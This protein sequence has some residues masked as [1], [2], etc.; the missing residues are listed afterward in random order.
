MKPLRLL[1][2]ALAA[3][4]TFLAFLPAL[5][6]GWVNFDDTTNFLNNPHYRGLG[7]AQIKWMFTDAVL[8]HYIPLT[9]LTLGL[10]YVLWGMDARG[11]HLTSVLFH[12]VN[13]VVFYFLVRRLLARGAPAP[14]GS[15]AAAS[16]FAAL[17]FS[18]HP[19]RV[20]SVAWIT[21]RRD[22]VSGLFFLLT[23]WAYLDL[24]EATEPSLR[25][26]LLPPALF[27]L[28]LLARANCVTLLAALVILDVYPLRRLG[29]DR[30][31]LGPSARAAWREKVPY[32]LMAVAA[33]WVMV[34]I[35]ADLGSFAP[36]EKEG[37][38]AQKAARA[39]YVLAFHVRKTLW[40]AELMPIYIRPPVFDPAEAR[41]LWSAAAVCALTALFI[42]LRR[43]WPAGLAV[44]AYYVAMLSPTL[45]LAEGISLTADH[46]SYLA[47]LGFPLLAGGAWLSLR[48][49]GVAAPALIALLAA[50]AL[51]RAA[52][53]QSKVW[54]DS[55]SLWQHTIGIDPS[56]YIA[57][58]NLGAVYRE[59]G[60]DDLALRHYQ[61]SV[62]HNPRYLQPYTNIAQILLAAGR[63]EEA[64]KTL[65]SVQRQKPGHLRSLILLS[66]V[67]KSLKQPVKAADYA[68]KAVSA[69]PKSADAANMFGILLL[70]RGRAGEAIQYFERAVANDPLYAPGYNNIGVALAALGRREQAAAYYA[71][72]V[73][74]NPGYAR[75]HL[76][77]AAA[78]EKLGKADSA[79]AHREKAAALTGG[80]R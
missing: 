13:A 52:W 28:T 3:L 18:L 8:G 5:Q 11:Y 48:R 20:D 73:A 66:E 43:R 57:H 71:K 79:K 12:C 58:N 2:P 1:P 40:P 21:E 30:G 49:A 55:E 67:H 26:K 25:Q 14:E 69:H 59:R 62:R 46:Y 29:G 61:E 72:A 76:N 27:A 4:A 39:F 19:L 37:A 17:L 33:A 34:R 23:I 54:K 53:A 22:V 7:W 10:D 35:T 56:N 77:L 32:V 45:G 44:W 31:W 74:V 15:L 36:I 75:A 78:Y 80:G 63:P 6:N 51:A 60:R 38:L 16:L 68:W 50:G 65:E 70:E 41:F 9:W 47:C 64:I 24:H 42:G